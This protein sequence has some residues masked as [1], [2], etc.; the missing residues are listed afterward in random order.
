M[1]SNAAGVAMPVASPATD[2]GTSVG[3]IALAAVTL[4]ALLATIV[5][6]V[7]DR[8]KAEQRLHDERQDGRDH[9]QL[10]EARVVEVILGTRPA[11]PE[12]TIN[13]NLTSM[14]DATEDLEKVL[15]QRGYVVLTAAVINHGRYP[16]TGIE[17]HLYLRQQGKVP[18]SSA[19]RITGDKAR[20][21]K[22]LGGV[23]PFKGDWTETTVLTPW[24]TGLALTSN[25][26]Q[27]ADAVDAHVDVRWTDQWGIRWENHYGGVRKVEPNTLEVSPAL[28]A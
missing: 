17:F 23:T 24:D 1:M 2:I 18:F 20:D 6:T 22:L 27:D 8:R 26:M 21:D 11:R 14:L 3:T 15:R 9:E 12:D 19:K 10:A 7:Q 4:L 5:I 16:I 25:P 28:S 13:T